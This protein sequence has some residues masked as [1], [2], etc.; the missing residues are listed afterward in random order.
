MAT[1]VSQSTPASIRSW[2]PPDEH[3]S[4]APTGGLEERLQAVTDTVNRLSA[5]LDDQTLAQGLGW[6]SIGLG[7]AELLAPR[8][9][10]RAIGVGEHPVLM[11]LCGLREIASGLGLLSKRAPGAWAWAR[12]A[13]DAMDLGL[14]NAAARSE[15]ADTGRIA[16]A[17]T[18][19]VSVTALDVYAGQRLQ[20]VEG[21]ETAEVEVGERI[22]IN[23]TPQ[24]LHAF[25]R[26]FENLPRFM[27]HLA[28]VRVTGERTSHWIATAPAG[29]TVE[30]DAEIT[31]DQPG[32]RISWRTLPGSEIT[33]S[34][35]VNFEPATHGRGTVVRVQLTYRPPAGYLGVQIARLL[36]EEPKVQI[37]DDLR[38]LKQLLETGEIATTEGQPAG[39][40]SVL[41]RT[42]LG[43]RLQ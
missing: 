22:T 31:D 3:G 39:K 13:G 14:L 17:A 25:W 10:G 40:R 37:H 16:L 4:E 19:V 33:H 7:V 36:G 15:D 18:A 21:I 42:L 2:P 12:V 35:T 26:N 6:F 28:S 24:D 43:R 38:R 34:G 30:W 9:L 23:S 5:K 32:S 11:R 41:G 1:D 8:Q 27:R 20:G 29:R